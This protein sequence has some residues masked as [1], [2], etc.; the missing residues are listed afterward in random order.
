MAS[1]TTWRISSDI[2]DDDDDDEKEVEDDV[3]DVVSLLIKTGR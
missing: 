2:N 1:S 3:V